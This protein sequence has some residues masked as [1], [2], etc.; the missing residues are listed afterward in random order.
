MHKANPDTIITLIDEISVTEQTQ[1]NQ[2][3]KSSKV[4]VQQAMLLRY[5][6][7]NPKTIQAD[8]VKITQRKAATVSTLL[9]KMEKN[10]LIIRTIPVYN[11]RNKELSLTDQGRRVLAFFSDSQKEVRQQLVAGL[12][13][14]QQQDLIK[15]LQQ[16]R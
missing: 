3:L 8:I 2:I 14:A 16:M 4:T 12:T 13:E 10:G 6:D 9:G 1:L 11:T 5:I 15:L 7:K